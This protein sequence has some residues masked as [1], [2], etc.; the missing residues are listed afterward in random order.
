MVARAL[1]AGRIDDEARAELGA[2]FLLGDHRTPV[3][4]LGFLVSQ[5]SEMAVR[6]LSPGLNDPNTA[7]DCVRRLGSLVARLAEREFPDGRLL[8]EQGRLRAVVEPVR[9]EEIVAAGFDAIRHY[10]AR[11]ARVAASLLE[12][13]GESGDR[14]PS[15]ARREVLLEHVDEVRAVFDASGGGSRRDAHLV[16]AAWQRA[17]RRLEAPVAATGEAPPAARL[18]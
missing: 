3:Q 7:M 5:L 17:R 4:D 14:G 9:F 12:A 15:D 8:D 6:A 16:E 1:P 2:A 11:D 13:L 18:G 10:G